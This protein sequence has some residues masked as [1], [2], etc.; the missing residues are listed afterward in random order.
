MCEGFKLA[1]ADFLLRSGLLGVR[2]K[3][4]QFRFLEDK[5]ISG[6]AVKAAEGTLTLSARQRLPSLA[7]NVH[8]ECKC[9]RD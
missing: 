4:L 1:Y 3:L 7:T 6:N 8:G 9:E 2:A 5:Q